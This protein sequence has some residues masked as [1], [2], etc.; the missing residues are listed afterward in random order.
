VHG[1]RRWRSK[2]R[3][4][5]FTWDGLH[6]EVEV[7]NARGQ[8]LGSVDAVTGA[9]IKLAVRGRRINV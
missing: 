6:G 2:D 4:R 5:L 9:L 1:D 3:K 7:F 8:H